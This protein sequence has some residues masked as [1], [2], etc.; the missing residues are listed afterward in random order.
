MGKIIKILA[1]LVVIV[2]AALVGIILTTDINQYK[3]EIV[4]LVK[5]NTG[6]DFEISGDLKLAPSLIPTIAIEGVSLGNASWAKEKTMLSVARFE[7]QV[8]LMP[9][10]K[11]NI[12]VI[13]LI[14]IEPTIHLETNKEG[15]GNWVFTSDAPEEEEEP[16]ADTGPTDLP[17]LAVNEVYIE[18]AHISYKDGKTGETT[19]LLIDEITVNSSS[20]SDP[21]S[22]YVKASFNESPLEVTGTLGS[23][24]NL[25]DNKDYPIN[26]KV[27]IAGADISIAGKLGQPMS[28]KGIDLLASLNI[29]NLS[30]LNQVAG[31]ELPDVGPIIF[32]GKLSDT[33][34]GYAIKSMSTQIMEY[35]ING[36]VEI[37]LNGERPKLTANLISDSLDI[38]PFQGEAKEEVKKE[39]VF[40]SDPLPLAGLKAADVDLK[41]KTKKLITKDLTINDAGLS[42]KLNNGKLQLI[43]KGKAAGGTLS[44]KIDLDA[45]NGKS[46]ALNIDI[47]I[48][49]IELGQ[50]PAIKEKNLL[51]GGKTDITIK[52]KGSGASVSKI[53]AGLN[54][55]LLIKTG[56]GKI[57]NT[58]LD[59]ASADALISAL[60]MLNPGAKKEEGSTLECLV[61]NFNINDG[62]AT[63]DKGIAILTNQMNVI[64][65][66]SV[67][68]KTEELDIGI[69]PKAREG[70]GLNLGKLAELVRL[71]GTLANPTPK[72]DTKAALKTGLS[73][74]AAVA[75]GGLSLLAQGLLESAC[76]DEN[77]CDIALGKVT[78]K[79][80]VAEKPAEEK[81][82]VEKTTDTVKDA[83]GA[84]GDK[85]KGFF[86][87]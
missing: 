54:G 2:I 71:G 43:Q 24:T 84:I 19:E 61:V 35:K 75:T 4:Q 32:N 80:A 18:N 14:L 56:K 27:D 57:S 74:G 65:S 13:R 70:I 46:A 8:V 45:S 6:R 38:S 60:S 26:I 44:A 66:G 21:M 17:A 78:K 48:K 20:F 5:D 51:T 28:A 82:V 69:T 83:A 63:A 62:I 12:Q 49:Q 64:G 86:G 33:K 23:I 15:V 79:K 67:N 47:E 40:S 16:T 36:D 39:K 77:P 50:I 53:M 81:S 68:L 41:F 10:L 25:L 3:D 37:G 1:I 52:A 73:V 87:D 11:K 42:L 9:L 59:V 31:S 58:A 29:N 30:D 72:T 34:S 85:L 55:K 7:A 76:D 22:L